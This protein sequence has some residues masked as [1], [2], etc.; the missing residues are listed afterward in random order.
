MTDGTG[1]DDAYSGH[2]NLARGEV[3]ALPELSTRGGISGTRPLARAEK[4]SVG[5]NV[6]RVKCP[7]P[8][9]ISA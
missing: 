7:S 5:N 3:Q 9:M 1:S 2:G 8:C 6:P 4:P